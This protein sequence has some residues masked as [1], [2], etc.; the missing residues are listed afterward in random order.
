MSASAALT[1]SKEERLCS[2]TLI[3]RL[4]NGGGS[5]S[6]TA[7]PLRMVYLK[8]DRE[9]HAP[10]V[11][12]MVSVPKRCFKRA[13]KRNRV[14]RQVRE[15][16]RKQKTALLARLEM[17]TGQQLILAFI[18]LDVKLYDSKAVEQRVGNLI[19]RVSEKL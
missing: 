6:M 2:R 16:F 7:F 18:W 5:R 1:L 3:D 13:V 15:A 10:Q 8:A 11:Q 4:F 14:K 9:P 17:E 19:E 12:M